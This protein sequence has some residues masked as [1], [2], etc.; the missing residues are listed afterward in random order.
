MRS[1]FA[2]EMDFQ[3]GTY[4]FL[5]SQEDMVTHHEQDNYNII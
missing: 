1:L 2:Y 5:F 4:R 3:I